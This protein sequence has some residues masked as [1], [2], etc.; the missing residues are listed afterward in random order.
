MPNRENHPPVSAPVN[1]EQIEQRNRKNAAGKR[2]MKSIRWM[3]FF[4]VAAQIIITLLTTLV[5]SFLPSPLHPYLQTGIASLIAYAIPILFYAHAH[6]VKNIQQA[7]DTFRLHRIRPHLLPLVLLIGAGAQMVMI[8]FNLPLSLLFQTDVYYTPSAWWELILG[9]FIIGVIPAVFEEFMFR[10][11][12]YG[13]M[14]ELNTRAAAIF[15][16]VMF[17]LLHANPAGF[18]GYLFMGGISIVLLRRTGSLLATMLFH[19]AVNITA[20]I[21]EFYSNLLFDFPM[22]MALLFLGGVLLFAAA[23]TVF[24]AITKTQPDTEQKRTATLL[25]QN[26]FSLPVFLSLIGVIFLIIY[27][28]SNI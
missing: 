2:E 17:A 1:A 16:T 22:T 19:F 14:A 20:L 26:F 4:I 25:G 9:I 13:T 28:V 3:L 8:L 24:C 12:L 7:K 27:T 23:M 6:K 11:I 5:A 18:V 15:T 21:M 10:G